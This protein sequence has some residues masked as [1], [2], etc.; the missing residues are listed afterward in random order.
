MHCIT[1]FKGLQIVVHHVHGIVVC[2]P[3]RCISRITVHVK[4]KCFRGVNTG[5]AFIPTEEGITRVGRCSQRDLLIKTIR[6]CAR[7]S[8]CFGIISLRG[9]R[10]AI[11]RIIYAQYLAV[12]TVNIAA[13]N[14]LIF[15]IREVL[16][17]FDFGGYVCIR[18]TCQFNRFVYGIVIVIDILPVILNRINCVFVCLPFCRIRCGFFYVKR[19]RFRGANTYVAF[20]P[21]EEG[22]SCVG[23][24]GQRDLLIKAIRA[25]LVDCTCLGV[26]D[27]RRDRIRVASIVYV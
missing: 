25:A 24:C 6:T 13:Y 5:F 4:R 8:T 18:R 27:F 14:T 1:A 11:T 21:T 22:I 7:N 10:I 26:I 9:N 16:I 15:V 20:V 19:K 3:L 12:I 2:L 23:R 17:S